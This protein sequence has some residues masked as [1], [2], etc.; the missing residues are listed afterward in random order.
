MD[1]INHFYEMKESVFSLD[2]A[3]E[4]SSIMDAVSQLHPLTP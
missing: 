1:H 3:M 2:E 4:R